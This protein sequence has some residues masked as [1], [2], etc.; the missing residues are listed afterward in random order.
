MALPQFEMKLVLATVLS[1]AQMEL[2]QSK[3]VQPVRKGVVLAPAED[4]AVV[5]T[6]RRSKNERV[7]ETS[8]SSVLN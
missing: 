4:L 1:R 2:L 8:S 6:L 7:L 3:L 5:V